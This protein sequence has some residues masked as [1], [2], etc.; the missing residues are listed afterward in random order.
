MTKRDDALAAALTAIGACVVFR[1]EVSARTFAAN[2]AIA[3]GTGAKDEAPA[4]EADDA[5][6]KAKA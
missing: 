6:A 3:T 2:V 4:E 1:D 5:K